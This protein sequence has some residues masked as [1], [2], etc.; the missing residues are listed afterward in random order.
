MNTDPTASL[1]QTPTGPLVGSVDATG[2]HSFLG[3]PY[4]EAPVGSRR[5]APPVRRTPWDHPF[6]ATQYGPTAPQRQSEGPLAGVLPNVV[7]PGDEYLN[8]NIWTPDTSAS[9]PVMVFIHGGSWTS[10]SGAIDGYNGHAFARDGIVLVT[11]NYR[12]GVDGFLWFGKGPANLG[13]LDQISALEWVRDNIKAFGGDPDAV[14][15]FGESAGAMSIGALLGMP[16][17]NGLFQKAILESGAAHHVIDAP[18][19]KL[20][21][22]RFAAIL[23]VAPSREAIGAVSRERI[24]DAQGQVAAEVSKKPRKRLWGDVALNGLPFEPVVDG[25]SLPCHP[26]RAIQD[27]AAGQIDILI[28]TNT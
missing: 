2:I 22:T 7:I 4:A 1:I 16:A 12:L 9:L 26:L 3:I 17:A 6:D 21:A 20:V 13:L 19:A 27:G 23:G 28:G 25:Y 8:L 15:V 5:F 18:S 10:G 14:T 11:I 24:L